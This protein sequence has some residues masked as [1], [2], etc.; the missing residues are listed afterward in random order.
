MRRLIPFLLLTT[1]LG[2]CGGGGEAEL[3]DALGAAI[4]QEAQPDDGSQPAVITED[5]AGCIGEAFVSSV[6]FETFESQGIT[7][8]AVTGRSGTLAELVEG[9]DLGVADPEVAAALYDGVQECVDLQ[10]VLAPAM[11][12]ELEISD[13]SATCFIVGLLAEDGFRTTLVESLIGT[14]S[15]DVLRNPDPTMMGTLLGLLN[16]CLTPEEMSKILGR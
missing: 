1:I 13:E 7:A 14:G 11:S 12:A 9:K 4:W 5:G 15:L 8:D 10:G 3:S 16:S 6:G 2:A